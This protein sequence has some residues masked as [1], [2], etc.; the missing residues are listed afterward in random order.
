MKQPDD[1]YER[2]KTLSSIRR[3]LISNNNIISTAD[4]AN[5][6]VIIICLTCNYI[7]PVFLLV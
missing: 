5:S 2:L 7:I 1:K 6:V 4:E 3:K